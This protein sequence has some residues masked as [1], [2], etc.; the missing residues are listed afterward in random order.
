VQQAAPDVP[1][2][3]MH[4]PPAAFE[5]VPV[6]Q[7]PQ[8]QLSNVPHVYPAFEQM[9]EHGNLEQVPPVDEVHVWSKAHVPQLQP[10]NVPQ[11]N[12]CSE[13]SSEHDSH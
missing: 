2:V 1:H 13:Q 9:V 10:S 7:N 3:W 4:V 11:E 6:E 12:P 5:Q 8:L